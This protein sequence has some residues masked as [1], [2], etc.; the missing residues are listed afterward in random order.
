[1]GAFLLPANHPVIHTPPATTSWASC[2]FAVDE[3]NDKD[4]LRI[5]QVM[6]CVICMIKCKKNRRSGGFFKGRV[7]RVV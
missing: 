6:N 2:L 5:T 7:M 4:K 3:N 1:M